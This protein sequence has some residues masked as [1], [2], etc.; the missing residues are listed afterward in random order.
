[1]SAG[2]KVTSMNVADCFLGS[3]TADPFDLQGTSLL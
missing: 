1:M 3:R 2:L